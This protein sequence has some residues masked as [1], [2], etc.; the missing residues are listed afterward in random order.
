M[1][2]DYMSTGNRDNPVMMMLH[3]IGG[4]AESFTPQMQ[5]FSDDFNVVLPGTCPVTVNPHRCS[6]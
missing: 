2:I 4:A 1:T 6:H 3:G 5:A